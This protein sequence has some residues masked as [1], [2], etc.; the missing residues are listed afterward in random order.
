MQKTKNM[1]DIVD[2]NKE[3]TSPSCNTT[4]Y[5]HKELYKRNGEEARWTEGRGDTS[6]G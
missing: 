4:L 5:N 2:H 1:S 6:N 3:E